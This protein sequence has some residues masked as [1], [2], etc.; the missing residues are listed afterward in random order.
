MTSVDKEGM[1]SGF[2]IELIKAV[3]NS[4]S[5]PVICSGGMGQL[6]DIDN[7]VDEANADAVAMSHVLHYDFLTIADIREYALRKGFPVRKFLE[8]KIIE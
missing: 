4:V 2:D 7:V 3:T 6:S 8:E 1:A 5:I